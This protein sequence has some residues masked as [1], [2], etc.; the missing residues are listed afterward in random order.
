ML[1]SFDFP[2][3]CMTVRAGFG[4][5]LAR[6][7]GD[8]E[9]RIWAIGDRGPNLKVEAAVEIYGLEALAPLSKVDGAK[10]MPRLDLG[11]ML[12][13]LQVLETTVE[14][15]Q[16]VRI[17]GEDGTPVSGVAIPASDHV[18]AEPVFDL[19]GNLIP[20]DPNGLDTEGVAVT[21]DG[22]FWV[23]DEF[24]PSLIRLNAQGRVIERLVP[25]DGAVAKD[26]APGRT[27]PAI[28]AK[29]RLNRGFEA[30]ALS[31][32]ELS[33]FLAFQSPLAHPDDEAFRKARHVRIWRLDRASGTVGAQFLYPLDP[34][35]SFKRD[36]AKGKFE[37]SDIKV[38]EIVWLAEDALLVLERGSAT[39][40]IYVCD[41]DEAA[42][43]SAPHLDIATRPTVEEL[44]GAR[45]AFPLPVLEKHLLFS[46]DDVPEITADI[47]GMVILSPT[48]LLL[49]NDNDF[50]VEGAETS[51]W[52]LV[53][54]RPVLR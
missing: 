4:S 52:K 44:S 45:K 21:R 3:A 2:K 30:I 42:A 41:L 36:N 15:V 5:G 11:P 7:Q 43:L 32:D 49:V 6:R 13:E 16:T 28:A 37:R 40:K 22:Q 54:E 8:P 23:G 50:G 34:P 38:S 35:K 47:E 53:F 26:D 31:K 20:S 18:L 14:L 10:I 48:E 46:T 25:H 51:F 1:G 19:E 39:T 33:L 24:G 12:A 29:R 17:A 9:G 27:L